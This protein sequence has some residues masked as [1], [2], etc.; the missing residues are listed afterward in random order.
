MLNDGGKVKIKIS[1]IPPPLLLNHH[2]AF[3]F[4][5][6]YNA[7]PNITLIIGKHILFVG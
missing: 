2:D 5:I 7:F 6:R 4:G 3:F 1:R